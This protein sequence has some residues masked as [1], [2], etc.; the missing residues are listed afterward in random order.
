VLSADA[1]IAA[2]VVI[3]I[4]A[5][6]AAAIILVFFIVISPF[7][8]LVFWFRVLSLFCVFIISQHL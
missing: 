3:V 2:A 5:A 1:L 6:K 7:R 4:A 8:F